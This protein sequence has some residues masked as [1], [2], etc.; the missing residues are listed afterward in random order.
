MTMENLDGDYFVVGNE[1]VDA[2]AN[3]K[4]MQAG[5]LDFYVLIIV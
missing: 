4:E 2:P 3:W 5:K 1:L